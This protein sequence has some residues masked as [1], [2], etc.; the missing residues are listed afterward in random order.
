MTGK[1]Y[2]VGAGCGGPELLTLRGKELLESCTAVAYDAL[3]DRRILRF[4]PENSRKIAV[5]KRSGAHSVPQEQI[6]RLLVE[7]ALS[8]ET[9][10]RLKGGDP[11]VFGRS[12]EEIAALR[13]AGVPFEVVPGISSC[14]AVPELAGIPV[15]ERRVS[16]GFRVITASTADGEQ[17]FE[18]YGESEET[19]VFLMGLAKLDEISAGLIRGGMSPETPAA[20]IS[21]GASPRQRTVRGRLCDIAEKAK[22]SP[23]PAIIVVGATSA[24]DL[25]DS[26]HLELSGVSAAVVGTESFTGRTGRLLA[27]KGAAVTELSLVKIVE[28]RDSS[29]LDRA[30][31]QVG[32]YSA[33]AFTSR[34]GAELFF[35]RI[36]ATKA[37]LRSLAGVKL[38]AVG[39][40]TAAALEEHGLTADLVPEE[41]TS[42]ALGELLTAQLSAGDRVLILRNENG[43]P[44]LAKRL[45][46]A[47]IGYEEI[48]LYSTCFEAEGELPEECSFVVFGSAAGVRGFVDLG[49]ILPGNAA[50]I[51]I[52]EETASAARTAFGRATVAQPHTAEGIVKT[53]IREAKNETI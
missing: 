17:S 48:P 6:S 37:D 13:E 29:A 40:S 28:N 45:G 35:R 15:T 30:L 24:E 32:S 39:S 23:S 14:I 22:N 21:E 11:F 44:E 38:A 27:E 50:V 16:R 36:R 8:G 10:V 26:A 5:G 31:S 47:G 52:G 46:T 51:C 25:R 12:S 42:A 9:V 49:Y 3:A 2:L 7:L 20:V 53:I 41:F 19:L 43:S 18:R 33:L 4:V 34:H 1:V